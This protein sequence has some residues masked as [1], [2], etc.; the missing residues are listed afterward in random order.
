L[1]LSTAESCTGGLLAKMLTDI[2][3][4]SAYF[5]RGVVTYS[6][7]SKAEILNVPM[8][9]IEEHGAV[10]AEVAEAMASGMRRL[11]KTDF[12]LSITGIAGPDGGTEEK[13]VGTTFIALS[14]QDE[15]ISRKFTFP[16]DRETNRARAAVAALNM[17]RINMVGPKEERE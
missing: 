5:D 13:P 4:S 14:S 17:V 12:A 11:A 15:T 6:N 16:T 9:L 10:S 2:P 8:E 7:Q 1:T 3:G